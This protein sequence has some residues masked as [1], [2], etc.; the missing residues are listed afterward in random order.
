LNKQAR[1]L[2]PI[3]LTGNFGS[4]ILR[5]VSTFKLVGLSPAL[6][7][8]EFSRALNSSAQ[9][10][11]HHKEHAVT[12]AAF[13]EIPW[14][15][16]GTLAAGRSQVIF[17]TPYLDNELVAL[18]YQSPERF[19]NS[20]LLA[21]R[22]VKANNTVLSE[23]P[24]DRGF[25]GDNS[26]LEFLFRRFFAEAT[27]KIDYYN[28]EGLPRL[29][30]PLDPVLRYLSSGLGI[31]G[32]H[33]Y[34]PYPHWFRRELA[35]YVNDKLTDAQTRRSSYWDSNFLECVA[36]E[37]IRGSKNYVS[38]I[39]AVLTLEAVERMFFRDSPYEVF[40]LKNSETKGFQKKP[41]LT[42]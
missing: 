41:V 29:L 22:L 14:N 8:R 1:Q 6:F 28:S 5:G 27:F 12:F 4:E 42:R 33:K 23:I 30:S 21:P 20:P 39:N 25:A 38:E 32:L 36:R 24:T 26:G 35:G 7:D 11:A 15:L 19:K 17:R 37:H 40:D 34:L 13:R 10:P 3:R 18:A 2:A 9:S 31:L 16:F